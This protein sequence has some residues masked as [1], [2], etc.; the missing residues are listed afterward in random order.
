MLPGTGQRSLPYWCP[1][2]Y[3]DLSS[4]LLDLVQ[5]ESGQVRLLCTLRITGLT[6]TK[7]LRL[8]ASRQES[9]VLL[10]LVRHS[11]CLQVLELAVMVL[12]F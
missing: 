11:P 2:L 4:V 9:A 6:R 5:L 12:V 1:A 8:L 10:Q 3:G 7:V